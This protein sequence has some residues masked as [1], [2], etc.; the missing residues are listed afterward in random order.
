MTG[1]GVRPSMGPMRSSAEI[2][3]AVRAAFREEPRLRGVERLITLRFDDGA[4]LMEGVV[5]DV[6]VKRLALERAASVPEVVGVVD[7]LRTLPAGE[8]GDA[9]VRALVRDAMLQEPAFRDLAVREREG[10]RVTALREPSGPAGPGIE[11]RVEDGVVTLDGRVP[12]LDH[13]RLAGVLA[14]WVPGS[15]DVV[16]GIAVDPDEEDTPGAVAD[17]VRSALE[18]DPFVDAGQVRVDVDGA[19]VT[20][21]GYVTSAAEREMAEFD[22]WYVFAVDRVVNLIEVQ[23]A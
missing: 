23:P 6:A 14:W 5:A 13:K 12:G 19:V 11:V 8:M 15:R 7:R 16:N 20:L 10:G 21:H 2:V 18:K 4:L 17:A 1:G 22:A 3:A 9:P